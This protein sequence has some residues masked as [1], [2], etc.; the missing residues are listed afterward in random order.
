MSVAARFTLA[1]MG[2]HALD[3]AGKNPADPV[4][5]Y[6]GGHG[7]L[8]AEVYGSD[9]PTYRRKIRAHITDLINRKLVR[10]YDENPGGRRAYEL[11]PK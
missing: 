2:H 4:G 6:W 7:L 11:L 5:V 3:S 9:T 8:A 1:C 10:I